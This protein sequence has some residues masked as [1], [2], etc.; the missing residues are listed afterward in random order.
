MLH[1]LY[2]S[3]DRWATGITATL[4]HWQDMAAILALVP[5][6]V[7]RL[8]FGAIGDVIDAGSGPCR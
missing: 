5:D 2:D 3:R 4:H 8:G 7:R 1:L 6:G